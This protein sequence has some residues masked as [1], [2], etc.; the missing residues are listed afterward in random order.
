MAAPT[1]TYPVMLGLAETLGIATAGVGA[2][3]LSSAVS[4][5]IKENPEI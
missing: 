3:A 2:T 1:L 5:K 4:D